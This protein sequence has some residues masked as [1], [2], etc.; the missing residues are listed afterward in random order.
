MVVF[1]GRGHPG[2]I[3]LLNLPQSVAKVCVDGQEETDRSYC[4]RS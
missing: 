1:F 4:R 2:K 3:I